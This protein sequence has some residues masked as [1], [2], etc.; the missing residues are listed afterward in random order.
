MLET[1]LACNGSLN[2][3]NILDDRAMRQVRRHDRAL[4]DA[5]LTAVG[6]KVRVLRTLERAGM[7][8][9]PPIATTEAPTAAPT[10]PWTTT[11]APTPTIAPTPPPP[12]HTALFEGCRNDKAALEVQL[13]SLQSELKVLH[14]R[15]NS[16]FSLSG[17]ASQ[18]A[19]GTARSPGTSTA[20]GVDVARNALKKVGVVHSYA[21]GEASKV[22][23]ARAPKGS[24]KRAKKGAPHAHGSKLASSPH[25]KVGTALPS[26]VAAKSAHSGPT[27]GGAKSSHAAAPAHGS[28]PKGGK[29][30]RKSA[31]AAVKSAVKGDRGTKVKKAHTTGSVAKTTEYHKPT[32][33][34]SMGGRAHSGVH[35]AHAATKTARVKSK[36]SRPRTPAPSP[37]RHKAVLTAGSSKHKNA[38]APTGS[39][40]VTRRHP[41]ALD[42]HVVQPAKNSAAQPVDHNGPS[43]IGDGNHHKHHTHGKTKSRPTL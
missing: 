33:S 15:L 21:V 2:L 1:P 30:R 26:K 3:S 34:T 8:P 22:R 24:T 10:H 43:P 36:A 13:A 23:T 37:M 20:D 17:A 35:S 12:N 9:R 6:H 32:S 27:K 14:D 19:E 41:H 39:T 4:H 38:G 28:A 25:S 40:T 31:P 7:A 42:E 18:P 5:E 16:I 29:A 11:T